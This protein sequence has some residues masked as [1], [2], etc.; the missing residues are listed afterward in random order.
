MVPEVHVSKLADPNFSAVYARS[1][2]QL[3]YSIFHDRLHWDVKTHDGMEIDE[4]DDDYSTY[5]VVRGEQNRVIGCW[6][7]RPTTTPYMLQDTFPQLLGGQAAPSNEHVWELSRFAVVNTPFANPQYG[8]G[9]TSLALMTAA[10]RFALDHGIDRYVTVTSV[11]VERLMK[12]MGLQVHRFAPPVR[13]GRVHS[14]AV[15]VDIDTHTYE[16]VLSHAQPSQQEAA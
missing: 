13:I 2:F 11:A 12:K 14:V 5:F 16:A 1:M 15:W 7:L 8:F 3:R 4:F 6:R 9:Y 10:L